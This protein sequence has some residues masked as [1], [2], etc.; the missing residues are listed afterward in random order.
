MFYYT[1]TTGR[2]RMISWRDI[3]HPTGMENWFPGAIF[4]FL[5]YNS[6]GKGGK[7]AHTIVHAWEALFSLFSTTDRLMLPT[8]T[9]N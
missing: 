5:S 4:Q 3:C 2:L 1:K 6:L 8:L 7:V 9:R